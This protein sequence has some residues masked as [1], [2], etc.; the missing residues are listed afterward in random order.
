MKT[1]LTC[2][3]LAVLL[4]SGAAAGQDKAKKL[5]RWVDKDGKVQFSDT[6]PDEALEQ[7]RTEISANSGRTTGEV[8]RALTPEEQA[9]SDRLAAE[10]EVQQRAD[11]KQ[12]QTEEA[13]LASFQT[14]EDLRR[15]YGVRVS[16]MQENLNAI[17]AGIGSQRNSL[18]SLLA[19]ASEAELAGQPVNAMQAATI[20]EL[21]QEMAKQQNMLIIKQAE[22]MKLD[23]D[24]DYL[25]QRFR[26][27][28]GV[29][30]AP[31]TPEAAAPAGDDPTG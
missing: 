27:L 30:E 11:E 9:E 22:L 28:K 12:R 4:A 18:T 26:E 31:A 13:M 19:D 3:A 8:G 20:R 6:L 5:Y 17:E 29:E 16:L 10:R 23:E 14:E 15:S 25:V 7:A 2:I 24:L 1:R 21:R